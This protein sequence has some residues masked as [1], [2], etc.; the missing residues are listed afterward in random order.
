[1]PVETGDRRLWRLYVRDVLRPE[2]TPA[3]PSRRA[4]VSDT[5]LAIALTVA[6]VVAAGLFPGGDQ[7]LGAQPQ[8]I[9]PLR[10][11]PPPSVPPLP[12]LPPLP[13]PGADLPGQSGPAMDEALLVALTALPLAARRR[14]PLVTFWAVLAAAL[15]TSDTATWI[16]VLACAIAAYG[17]IAY[18]RDR[19]VA[20][21]S[22]ALAAVLAGAAFESVAPGLPTWL[23][24]FVVLLS[25]GVLAGFARFWPQRQADLR[26]AQEEATRRA[27]EVERSRIAGELH[28][29]VTHHVSV[30]LIQA[31]GARKVMDVA[32]QEAKQALLAVEA[33]GRAAMAELRHVMGLLAGPDGEH[34]GDPADGLE[35]QPGLDRLDTLVERV[36]GAG[37]AVS[38]TRSP[39]PG[40]LPAGMDL[41]AYRVVQEALTNTIKHAAG[42]AVSVAIECAGD[43]L[44]IEVTDT[45]GARK[46]RKALP[47]SG[48]GLI[49]L[50]ERLAVYGGTLDAG[51][52]PGGGYRIR[53]RLPWTSA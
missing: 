34:P 9:E 26:R 23:G 16:T 3:R 31:G 50:R 25:A 4:L 28:D 42:A 2:K 11:Q 32:P 49:G 30:M 7:F 24:P 29:V 52:L 27:V 44:E 10:F 8:L 20:V 46:A 21:A 41:A 48:R 39:P 15:V 43:W 18:S 51:P 6:A 33:G 35:P 53:A 40:P 12:V 38:V 36:R 19:L 1:V 17:V 13:S 45:G 47:R 5:A 37:M 22:L 14:F